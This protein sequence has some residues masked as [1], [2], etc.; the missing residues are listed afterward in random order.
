MWKD[1]MAVCIDLSFKFIIAR[2]GSGTLLILGMR[3]WFEEINK[4]NIEPYGWDVDKLKWDVFVYN[5][6]VQWLQFHRSISLSFK[7]IYFVGLFEITFL[8]YTNI[9]SNYNF[10]IRLLKLTQQF[11][12]NLKMLKSWGVN[13]VAM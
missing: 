6:L 7:R 13:G 3:Q 10:E 11:G 2:L 12:W 9:V 1:L 8:L 4:R 5:S